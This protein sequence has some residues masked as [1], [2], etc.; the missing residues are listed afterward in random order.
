MGLVSAKVWGQTK[1]IMFS[2]LHVL[3]TNTQ[4]RD[5]SSV[6]V[7]ET[8]LYCQ[9]THVTSVVKLYYSCYIAD[10]IHHPAR[11]ILRHTALVPCKP[12][13]STSPCLTH[14]L[15]SGL[16]LSQLSPPSPFTNTR[17][18]SSKKSRVW[19]TKEPAP[20]PRWCGNVTA[21]CIRGGIFGKVWA[22]RSCICVLKNNSAQ[23][24]YS[25]K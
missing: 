4:K 11:S 8:V 10:F 25:L 2:W 18:D 7:L 13:D 15:S 14:L 17:A 9:W 24:D 19:N 6:E 5:T 22:A 16:G 3:E 12:D 23:A 20:P 21:L 1:H